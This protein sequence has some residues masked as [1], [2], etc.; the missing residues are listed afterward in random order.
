VKEI[1]LLCGTK[2][3][4]DDDDYERLHHYNW[5]LNPAGYALRSTSINGKYATIRLHREIMG[6]L[7]GEYVDHINGDVLDNR[8]SNLRICTNMQNAWN[9]GLSKSNTSGY[10]GVTWKKERGKWKAE[11]KKNYKPIFLGYFDNKH[12]AARMYNFWAKDMFGEYARLNVINEG[13]TE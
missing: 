11:I 7:K 5:R 8:K 13:E 10:K 6:A 4:V 1:E 2:T 3:L 9:S 12:D